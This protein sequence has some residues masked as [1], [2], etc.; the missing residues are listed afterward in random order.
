M[1][2][3]TEA[4]Q[5][6]AQRQWADDLRWLL[7]DPRGRRVVANLID[8]A[9]LNVSAMTGNSMAFYTLGRHDY[10]RQFVNELREADLTSFRRMEDESLSAAKIAELE[11]SEPGD[12]PA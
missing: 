8:R 10:V 6:R 1:S 9:G 2:R 11:Q 4:R 3:R 7:G 5:K 12:D